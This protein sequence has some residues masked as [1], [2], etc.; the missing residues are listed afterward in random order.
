[1]NASDLNLSQLL[2]ALNAAG[3]A[4]DSE[5]VDMGKPSRHAKF[6]ITKGKPRTKSYERMTFVGSNPE[7]AARNAAAE[8]L[9]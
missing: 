8:V 2:A 4:Y 7:E 5:W 3:W 6:T 1:M 9:R